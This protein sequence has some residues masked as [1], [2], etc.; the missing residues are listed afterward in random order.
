ML[1][2]MPK[3][4]VLV[5]AALFAVGGLVGCALPKELTTANDAVEA[6][7][8][9]GKDKECPNEFSAAENLKNEAYRICKPCD[10]AKAIALANQATTQVAAL[11]PAKP[12]PPPAPAPA[13]AR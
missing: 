2:F 1:T 6:A 4:R 9:A 7:R 3:P 5:A 10:T 12:V 13:P 8:R 11:C